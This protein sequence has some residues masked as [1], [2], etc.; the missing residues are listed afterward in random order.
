MATPITITQAPSSVFNWAYGPVPITLDGLSIN[1]DKYVLQVFP[2]GSNTPVADI[3]Q[4]PNTNGRAIFDLRNILQSQV[5]PIESSF[6]TSMDDSLLPYIRIGGPEQ[7]RYQIAIG[8]QQGNNPPVMNSTGGVTTKYGPYQVLAGATWEDDVNIPYANV[9]INTIY[10]DDSNP[11]C[12]QSLKTGAPLTDNADSISASATG[13]DF[14]T[15]YNYNGNLFRFNHYAT[16]DMFTTWYQ[17]LQRNSPLPDVKAQG[18]EAWDIVQYNGS[19]HIATSTVPNTTQYGGGPNINVGDGTA[20]SGPYSFITFGSGPSNLPISLNVNTTHYYVV[21]LVYTN[22]PTGQQQLN[23]SD[24]P[25]ADPVRV[26]IIEPECNDFRPFQFSWTNSLGYKDTFTFTKREDR[27]FTQNNNTY[28]QEYAD[29]AGTSYSVNP[30]DR[31]STVYSQ[32][33]KQVYTVQ[34]RFMSDLEANFLRSLFRS[35]DVKVSGFGGFAAN[36]WYAVKLLNT[37]WTQK[38]ARKDKLFQYTV[39]FEVPQFNLEMRG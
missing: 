3:R 22:C 17:K 31:G 30:Y 20:V 15:R 23:V 1:W 34:S 9:F 5:G 10:G 21:P 4:A 28:L 12:T 36:K 37:S 11:V 39:T 32:S 18:I 8:Y 13:D 16:D 33:M 25:V 14:A 6:E 19:T 7:F 2:F 26:N 38:T 35:A 29:Y 24:F 27:Q